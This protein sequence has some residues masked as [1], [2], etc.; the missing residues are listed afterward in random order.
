LFFFYIVYTY[1]NEYFLTKNIFALW[2][3]II[4]LSPRM[5]VQIMS[6][7]NVREGKKNKKEKKK[8]QNVKNWCCKA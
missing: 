6:I 7:K 4:F 2:F 8:E 5:W 1:V 3:E